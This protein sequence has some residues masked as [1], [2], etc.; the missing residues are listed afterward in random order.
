MF[1]LRKYVKK[2]LMYFFC[3]CRKKSK[4]PKILKSNISRRQPK[5]P[6]EESDLLFAEEECGL[7][8]QK[9]KDQTCPWEK[10]WKSFEIHFVQTNNE[11]VTSKKREVLAFLQKAEISE[12]RI[13]PPFSRN[14]LKI[15]YP[16]SATSKLCRREYQK[17]EGDLFYSER[18][19]IKLCRKPKIEVFPHKDPKIRNIYFFL[20]KKNEILISKHSKI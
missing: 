13:L 3:G 2:Y 19:E 11:I 5:N 6:K 8:S 15:K 17:R 14:G 9:A 4:F 1:H 16:E 12:I 18:K 20:Q 7:G 10:T